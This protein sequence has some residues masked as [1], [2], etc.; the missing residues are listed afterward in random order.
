MIVVDSSREAKGALQWS[1]S[2]TVQSQDK[3][4]LLYVIKPSKQGCCI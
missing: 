2:H 3:V 4:V 1:L